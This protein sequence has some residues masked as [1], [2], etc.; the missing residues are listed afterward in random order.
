MVE[1]WDPNMG[2][3]KN[4]NMG[5]GDEAHRGRKWQHNIGEERESMVVVERGEHEMGEETEA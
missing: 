3:K 2:E 5:E 1:R 4:N